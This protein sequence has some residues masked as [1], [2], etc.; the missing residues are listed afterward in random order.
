[1]MEGASL[2]K[3]KHKNMKATTREMVL[4]TRSSQKETP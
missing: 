4:E 2:Q 1:M 3:Q